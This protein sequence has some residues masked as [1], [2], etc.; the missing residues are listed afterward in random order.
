VPELSLVIPCYNEAGNVPDLVARLAE[1]VN[2]D[3]VE[4]ILVDN[5]SGDDTPSV[6]AREIETYPN[7]RTIRVAVNQ[8]YGYGILCGLAAAKGDILAWT[9]ADLQADPADVLEGLEV[10]RESGT[11][12]QLFVKGQRYGRPIRDM[13]FT[14][15]MAL[16]EGLVLGTRMWDIN[17]QPTMFHRH[18]FDT[19]DNPP[20]DFSLDLFAYHMAVRTGRRISRFPVY[21]GLR[22]AGVGHNETLFAKLHYSRRTI[23]YSFKLRR[24]LVADRQTRQT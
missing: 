22:K 16:F 8:G 18:F 4:I 17:A 20:H 14:W 24:M 2:G 10:F 11:P 9:H 19:W 21:F 1:A 23:D 5:G 3:N 7:V 15:G 6:L 12:E 13:L